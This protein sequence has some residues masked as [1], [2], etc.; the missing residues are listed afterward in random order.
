M[1]KTL[2]SLFSCFKKE[3]LCQLFFYPTK[4]DV[5]ICSSYF[6]ITDR[7][8]LNSYFHFWHLNSKII[9]ENEIDNE[10]HSLFESEEDRRFL[11]KKKTSIKMLLRDVIWKFSNWN[12]IKFKSWMKSQQPNRIF[13]APGD[14]KFIY[15][16]AMTISNEYHIPIITYFCDDYYGIKKPKKAF[17][18]ICWKSLRKK[19]SQI[20]EKSEFV[21]T[22][23]QPLSSFYY[24]EFGKK[25]KTIM[26]GTDK[27]LDSIVK[28][29]DGITSFV[30]LGNVTMNRYRSLIDIGRV[31]DEL[32]K[33][34]KEYY[35]D[36]Y[37]KINDESI[38]RSLHG[39]RTIR[40]HD[41]VYGEEYNKTVES[42]QCFVHVESFDEKTID[43]VKN[44][45]STKI[46]EILSSGKP[47]LAYG[48]SHI[49]SIDHLKNNDCAFV[50]NNVEELKQS[51]K[52]VIFD[53]AL[54]ERKLDN[55]INVAQKYHQSFINS[56][57]LKKMLECCD[58]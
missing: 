37:S 26:T 56:M 58:D 18:Y 35:L 3:E 29:A 6:R 48:P 25:T 11:K 47:I 41:F 16:I 10:F 19:I 12:D 49:A 33:N 50:A 28:F 15:N 39:I 43:R 1:G 54:R 27:K 53:Y 8:V 7:N 31:L 13:V 51:V 34:D 2:L 17:E 36:I 45:I 4:P 38:I 52:S 57:K 14:A 42:A 9:F 5:S 30:F 55:A 40:L 32:S 20:I 22:I 23:C 46:A 24:D 21:V 44:S